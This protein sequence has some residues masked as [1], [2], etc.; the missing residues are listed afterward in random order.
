MALAC[1]KLY[2][3]TEISVVTP[4]GTPSGA[5]SRKVGGVMRVPEGESSTAR[6]EPAQIIT[7][8]KH[9]IVYLFTAAKVELSRTAGTLRMSKEPSNLPT[10]ISLPSGE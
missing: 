9:R 5:I 8:R 10:A 7:I 4:R 2:P 3:T 6:S 1:A